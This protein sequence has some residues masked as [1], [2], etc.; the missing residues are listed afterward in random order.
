MHIYDSAHKSSPVRHFNLLCSDAGLRGRT[1]YNASVGWCNWWIDIPMFARSSSSWLCGVVERHFF[2]SPR[3]MKTFHISTRSPDSSTIHGSL[4]IYFNVHHKS[5]IWAQAQR[6]LC[7]LNLLP[8]SL[9]M[10]STAE[11]QIRFHETNIKSGIEL[12]FRVVRR[13]NEIFGQFE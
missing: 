13:S 7:P 9:F 5:A 12:S 6:S 8:L 1:T 11:R 2:F 4:I 10:I 3:N